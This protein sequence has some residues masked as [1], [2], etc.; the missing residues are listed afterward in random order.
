VITY[1]MRDV[2]SVRR[3]QFIQ[4]S[5][6]LTRLLL[7]ADERLGANR[8]KQICEGVTHRIGAPTKVSIEYVDEIPIAPSGK[9][10]Y[11]L[12]KLPASRQFVSESHVA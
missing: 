12:T 3:Y 5:L 9:F 8:E 11:I 6:D 4:E 10:R 2:P 1:L 7:V